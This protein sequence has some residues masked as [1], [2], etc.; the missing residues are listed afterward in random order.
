V[1]RT[2]KVTLA[3]RAGAVA[4]IQLNT[5]PGPLIPIGVA[6]M[7]DYAT[8]IPAGAADHESGVALRAALASTD[9]DV[10]VRLAVENWMERATAANVLA[11][12][13]GRTS[14]VILVGAHLDSWDLATGAVDNGSGTLAVLDAARALAEHARRTGETPLRTIRFAFWMGEEL[15]L[16]G[17]RHHV[18][19]RLASGELERYVAVLN[20]DVIGEPL[21]FAAMGRPEA[22][23][24]IAPVVASLRAAGLPLRAGVNTAGGLYSDHQPFLLQGVAVLAIDTRLPPQAAGVGHTTADT[25]D[26]IDERGISRSAAAAAALLWTLANHPE[27]GLPRWAEAGIGRRLEALGL[28]D[29]LERAGEWRWP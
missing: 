8:R 27:P 1:H 28:R 15:G 9:A 7:G 6:T 16:Y 24:V 14:D 23:T 18:Q 11:D 2:E 10:V 29:P 25:R 17:S 3:T 13:P 21:G 12:L 22:A 19:Q 4:F 26:R 5:Q 20:M